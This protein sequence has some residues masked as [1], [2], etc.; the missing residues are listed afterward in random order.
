[1]NIVGFDFMFS[2]YDCVWWE[3]KDIYEVELRKIE[4]ERGLD[5]K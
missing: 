2:L 1:M 4:E 5:N 3:F